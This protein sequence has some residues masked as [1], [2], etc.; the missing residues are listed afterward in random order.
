MADNLELIRKL[1]E[2]KLQ[3]LEKSLLEARIAQRNAPSAMESH[4]DTTRSEMEKMV[5]ALEI[6]IR[7]IKEKIESIP[8]SLTPPNGSVQLWQE[9]QINNTG[10]PMTVIFVPDGM[11]G[12][13]IGQTK[14]ISETTRLGR[15]MLGKRVGESCDIDGR[16][17]EVLQLK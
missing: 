4:S 17:V 1:F 5:T 16:K 2:H 6:E 8:A 9:V 3:I 10:T 14:L 7:N 11:G 12:D 15:A 13:T